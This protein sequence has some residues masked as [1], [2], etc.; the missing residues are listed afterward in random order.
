MIRIERFV[1]NPFQVNTY[2][3]HDD[4]GECIIID[5]AC[6]TEEEKSALTGFIQHK[7]LRPVRLIDTHCHI[8][9]ILGNNYICRYYNLGLEIHPEGLSFH[10]NARNQ[11]IAFGFSVEVLD[12]PSGYLAEG[13]QVIFGS[14]SLDVLYT[15]GHVNGSICLVEHSQGFVVTGDVLFNGSIGRTDL[16]TGN[17]ALLIKSIREK[18]LTLPDHYIVYPGHGPE[19]TIGTERASNPFLDNF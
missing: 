17:Y 2:V 7:K 3:I 10:K 13:D 6:Y 16:P 12:E 8:D 18:L 1:F 11:G 5:A 15:P 9:H 4:T 19:T 14:S